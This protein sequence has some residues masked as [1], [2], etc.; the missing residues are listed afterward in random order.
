M[1]VERDGVRIALCRWGEADPGKPP[2][3]L[4]HGTGF[5]SDIWD[6]VA[7]AL[8]PVHTVYAI[9][10][11]GHG[12]S[13]KP[14][15]DSYHFLDF[16]LDVC[17]VAEALD[18]SGLFGVGHSAGATD[19]LLAAGLAPGRFSRLLVMEPTVID[20]RTKRS[21]GSEL[22]EESRTFLQRTLYRR[23][24]FESANAAR[25]RLRAAP[26]FARW[27]EPALLAYVQHG[28]EPLPDGRVR[29]LCTPEIEAAMLRPIFEAMEQIYAGDGRGNPF[30]LLSEIE[31]PVCVATAERSDHIYKEMAS[32]ACAMIPAVSRW[33]FEGA[34]HCVAQEAP[35]LLLGAIETFKADTG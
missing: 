26:A 23:S 32:R 24:A 6:E 18:L 25:Q 20:P 19:L 31:C 17:A 33:T 7:N 2:L 27:S 21:E 9:D 12:A 14:T 13:G 22:S 30:H 8:A 10:R 1:W 15:G 4:V 3:L 5:V 29:L 28:F 34:G 35:A 11:R 16:A